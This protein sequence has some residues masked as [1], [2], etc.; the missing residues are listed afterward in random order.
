VVTAQRAECPGWQALTGIRPVPVSLLSFF[1][2]K[3]IEAALLNAPAIP[4][5][6]FRYLPPKRVDF[7][8]D[9]EVCFT[10]PLRFN[11]PFDI[12]PV[13]APVTNRAYL[14]RKLKE[15]EPSFEPLLAGL[16]RKEK[17]M[18]TR[19][20]NKAAMAEY[21]KDPSKHAERYQTEL[22]KRVNA[23]TGVLCFSGVK[24]NLLMWA[25][26]AD[27]HRGFVVE[28][29]TE[30]E[31]FRRLGELHQVRY[32]KDRPLFDVVKGPDMAIFLLKSQDWDYEKEFRIF[33]P[34]HGCLRR[35]MNGIDRFFAHLPR[36][37]VRA[38]YF[39][40]RM[41]AALKTE[42]SEIMAGTPAKLYETELHTK[43]FSLDFRRC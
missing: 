1:A 41:E 37:S 42:I 12:R 5:R 22:P 3:S 29:D 16:P 40:N 19:Q 24:D 14:K 9:E 27:S 8:R 18:L 32:R 15:S 31:G 38:V 7:L 43:Q 39:G 2:M 34:L 33:R 11:D 36:S 23:S 4:K 28:F 20:V 26:Y 25:H 21:L 13:F 35:S 30:D 17:K 6:V 10:P